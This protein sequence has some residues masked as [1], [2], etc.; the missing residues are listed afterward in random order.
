[1]S[2]KKMKTIGDFFGI[3]SDKEGEA[4]LHDLKRIKSENFCLLKKRSA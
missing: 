2:K 1:M 4:M 3:L